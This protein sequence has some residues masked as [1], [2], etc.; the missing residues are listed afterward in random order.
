M[1][2]PTNLKD[3]VKSYDILNKKECKGIVSKLKKSKE[4][5][6]HSYYS[7]AEN[8]MRSYE[9]D[10]EISYMLIEER[11]L[12]MERLWHAIDKYI[13]QDLAFCNNWFNTW[14]GYSQIRW[15]KYDV[16][17]RMQIHCDHIQTLFEGKHRGVPILTILGALN[18]DY[19]GGDL[20]FWVDKK[21]ELAVGHVVI[22]PSNFMYPHEVTP[23]TQGT[24][25]SFVSWVW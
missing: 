5:D 3:Y 1:S 14:S 23:V 9:D 21:I 18:D 19:R 24:R 7:P 2:M 22:F 17:T 10:L 25:Y 4:W 8:N 16:G 12:I 13:R 6:K 20:M 15:N 11:K